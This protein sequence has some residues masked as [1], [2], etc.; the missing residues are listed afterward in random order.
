M[1]QHA[2]STAP[3][4][5][6]TGGTARTG[7]SWKRIFVGGLALWVATVLVTLPPATRI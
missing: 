4:M 2:T 5:V 1:T 6:T 3:P 7:P